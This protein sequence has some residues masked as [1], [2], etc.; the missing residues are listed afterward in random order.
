MLLANAANRVRPEWRRFAAPR[1]FEYLGQDQHSH[2]AAHAVA[3]PGDSGELA[4]HRFLRRRI[5]V[6][7]L[8]RVGPTWEVRIAAMS[9]QYI[10]LPSFYPDIVLRGA[11]EIELGAGHV[12]ISVILHPGMI[13]RSMV[14]HEVEH[15][16][17]AALLQSLANACERRIAAKRRRN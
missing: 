8:Q 16:A 2:V 1:A 4:H 11:G 10:A 5:A 3:L 14:G 15:K 7:E 13:E 17:Q 6:I 12:I 9:E